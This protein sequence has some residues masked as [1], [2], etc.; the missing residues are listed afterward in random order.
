[1]NIVAPSFRSIAAGSVVI[2]GGY[3]VCTLLTLLLAALSA[4][5]WVLAILICLQLSVAAASGFV[6]ALCARTNPVLNGTLGGTVGAG[7]LLSILATM[8][9]GSG[10]FSYYWSF[11]T[12]ALLALV[13]ALVAVFAWPKKHGL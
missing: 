11:G 9:P 6:G 10:E 7:I 5:F 13:G 1:M 4:P 3:F 12:A 8:A 2:F